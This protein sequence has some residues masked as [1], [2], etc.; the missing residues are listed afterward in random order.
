LVVAFDC[1]QYESEHMV[2]LPEHTLDK[3]QSCLNAILPLNVAM[4]DTEEDELEA[5]VITIQPEVFH[6]I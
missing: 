4:P 1:I 2:F 3:I 6:Y 5:L